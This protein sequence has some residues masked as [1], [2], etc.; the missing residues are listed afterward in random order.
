MR[1]EFEC[2]CG[3]AVSDTVR[4]RGVTKTDFQIQCDDCGAVYAVT[5]TQLQEG[6]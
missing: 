1:F 2:D 6:N 3:E 4:G 5:V